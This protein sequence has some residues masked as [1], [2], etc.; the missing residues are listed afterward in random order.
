MVIVY[1][2]HFDGRAVPASWE[3]LNVGRGLAEELGSEIKAVV[4][5]SDVEGIAQE[6]KD[7]GAGEV[8]LADLKVLEHFRPEVYTEA[9]TQIVQEQGAEIVLFPTT[10]RA[11]ELAGMLAIDLDTGITP[12][13]VAVELEGSVVV[14]TRPIYAGKLLTKEVNQ[15]R[16]PQI[17]TTRSRSFQP[18]EKGTGGEGVI[19]R[20]ELE[21]SEPATEVQGYKE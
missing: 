9:V 3:A 6:A 1:I 7:Y 5:G 19:T 8:F 16:R 20:L 10:G 11:R 15:A 18:P 13:V 17:L 4:L 2:D 14:A 21:L 12:D